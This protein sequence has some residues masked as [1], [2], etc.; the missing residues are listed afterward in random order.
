[1]LM[2]INR[3]SQAINAT[4]NLDELL[5]ALHNGISEVLDTSHSFI[6]LY[7]SKTRHLTF[8][9]IYDGGV[10]WPEGEQSWYIVEDSNGLTDTVVYEKR[11]LLA[12]TQQEVEAIS[13]IPTPV[14]ERPIC[15]WLGVPIIQGDE[16]FGVLN[17][18]GYEPNMFDEDALRF[19]TTVANQ[20]AIA[21]NNVRLFQ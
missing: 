18:Q 15:S 16:V 17:V 2:T 4:L 10:R 9:L 13:P 6:A 19:L 8:P 5:V 21:L 12:R 11:P 3:I 14:G 20:A 7:D 1:E